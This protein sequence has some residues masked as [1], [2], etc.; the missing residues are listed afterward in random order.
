MVS[1]ANRDEALKC[2]HIS[3]Q[4]WASE[5]KALAHKYAMK[6]VSLYE[7]ADGRAWLEKIKAEFIPGD[8]D[9]VTSPDTATEKQ[10]KT[11]GDVK[12]ETKG[13]PTQAYT[14]EQSAEVR[15]FD[16]INKNDY[17][18]VLGVP[19]NASEADIKKAYRK[20]FHN[21]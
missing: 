18:A 1:E 7:T 5:Q 8:T 11:Q 6:S 12:K 16:K 3:R 10:E 13:E 14:A 20:V 17:Y 21:L 9:N 2:L 19:K 15:K 4:H